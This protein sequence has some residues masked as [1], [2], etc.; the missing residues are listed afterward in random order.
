MANFRKPGIERLYKNELVVR[1]TLGVM[2]TVI[3]E[4]EDLRFKRYYF[5]GSFQNPEPYFVGDGML[6]SRSLPGFT[7]L[8]KI[9][10]RARREAVTQ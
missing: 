6:V 3:E 5:S 2:T 7:P 10:E 1:A 9:L 4:G 8:T